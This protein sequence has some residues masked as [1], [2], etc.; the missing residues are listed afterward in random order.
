MLRSI[1][2]CISLAAAAT[3]A[4]TPVSANGPDPSE[5]YYR[6]YDSSG[7]FTYMNVGTPEDPNWVLILVEP[8]TGGGRNQN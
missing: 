2:T 5:P 7:C 3:I 6:T 8:P 4:V 1:L